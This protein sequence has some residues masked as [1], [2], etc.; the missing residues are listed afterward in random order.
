MLTALPLLAGC[1]SSEDRA[2]DEACDPGSIRQ[3]ALASDP[4]LRTPPGLEEVD[5][6]QS[7]AEFDELK[8]GQ[9]SGQ[10]LYYDLVAPTDPEQVLR[11]LSTHLTAHGWTVTG[12]DAE[13]LVATKQVAPGL[14]ARLQANAKPEKQVVHV[15]VA[16]PPADD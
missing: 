5:R 1:S 9:C 3:E 16:L 7:E 2:A 10:R 4:G 11:R 8:T 6:A 13:A 15:G 12:E 14:E